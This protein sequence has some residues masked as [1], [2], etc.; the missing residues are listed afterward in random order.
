MRRLDDT[1]PQVAV[2]ALHARCKAAK[3]R[4]A[5]L[6]RRAPIDLSASHGLPCAAATASMADV[7]DKAEREARALERKLA[8]ARRVHEELGLAPAH[9]T[10]GSARRRGKPGAFGARGLRG[11]RA[12]VGR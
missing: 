1:G 4:A 12:V 11:R 7:A 9:L 3:R 6:R 10:E 2:R 8:C 5:R